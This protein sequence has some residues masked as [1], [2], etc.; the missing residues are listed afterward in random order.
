[1]CKWEIFTYKF[2]IDYVQ[3]LQDQK[4]LFL[5]T[6]IALNVKYNKPDNCC[7]LPNAL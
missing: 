7:A 6:L 3:K 1:M 4:I 5:Q 2:R